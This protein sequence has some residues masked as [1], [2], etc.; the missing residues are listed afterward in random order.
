MEEMITLQEAKAFPAFC[1]NQSF[2][3]ATCL[4]SEPEQFPQSPLTILFL[5][6]SF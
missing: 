6:D 5:A 3:N 1:R 4:S 2:I